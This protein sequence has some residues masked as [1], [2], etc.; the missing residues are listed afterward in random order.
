MEGKIDEYKTKNLK[1]R[2]TIDAYC[3]YYFNSHLFL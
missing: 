2:K 1:I 3:G